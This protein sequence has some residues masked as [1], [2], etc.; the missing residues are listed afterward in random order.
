MLTDALGMEFC[1]PDAGPYNILQVG[2]PGFAESAIESDL[3]IWLTALNDRYNFGSWDVIPHPNDRVALRIALLDSALPEMY[4]PLRTY[5]LGVKGVERVLAHVADI[6][7]L[8]TAGREGAASNRNWRVYSANG[9]FQR[10]G[11]SKG[12]HALIHSYNATR[13]GA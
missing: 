10:G 8:A 5:Q 4:L 12:I 3:A 2:G 7:G 11:A 13:C 1:R 9:E 6:S